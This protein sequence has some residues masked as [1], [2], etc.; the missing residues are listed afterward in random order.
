MYS[1]NYC[2]SINADYVI[3]RGLELKNAARHALY[4]ES[5]RNNIVIEDNRFTF[6]GRIGGPIT[7]G[8]EGNMDSAIYANRGAGNL[9]IQRNLVEDPRGASND[10][11]TG[12]PAGP[13]AISLNNSSGGNVIRYNEIRSTEDH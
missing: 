1:S 4:I 5:E 9:T 3:I 7:Y 6:W 10:W 8:N 13:Q 12:H 2:I 11:D